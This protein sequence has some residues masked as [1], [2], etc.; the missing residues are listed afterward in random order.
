MTCEQLQNDRDQFF[1]LHADYAELVTISRRLKTCEP[2]DERT[3]PCIDCTRIRRVIIF[4]DRAW[5]AYMLISERAE[6][7]ASQEVIENSVSPEE[8]GG[9]LCAAP[10]ENAAELMKA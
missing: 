10:S 8:R 5:R 7:S 9:N 2:S 3:C 1:A 6:E 4:R